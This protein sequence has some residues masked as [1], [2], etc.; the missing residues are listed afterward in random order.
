MQ[1]AALARNKSS[2]AEAKFY[3][4]DKLDKRGINEGKHSSS[5]RNSLGSTFTVFP[6]IAQ[7][8]QNFEYDEMVK[9]QHQTNVSLKRRVT[10]SGSTDVSLVY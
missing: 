5:W 2:P 10:F 8:F 1:R 4:S 3:I 6:K 7:L 9:M